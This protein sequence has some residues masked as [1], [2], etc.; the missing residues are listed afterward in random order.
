LAPAC[1]T[2]RQMAFYLGG[3]SAAPNLTG[4]HFIVDAIWK[5]GP[6]AV[7]V[8]PMNY[9]M[10]DGTNCRLYFDASYP[11]ASNVQVSRLADVQVVNAAGQTVS[12]RQWRLESQ[13]S[14]KAACLVRQ[15]PNGKYVDTGTRY[16]LPFAVV[17]TQVP[18][19]FA[20]YP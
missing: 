1:G 8:Q 19:P 16:Y 5:L 11:E 10:H 12:A 7:V 18:Y 4:P 6:G 17:I 20:T 2:A 9:G 15:S 14:H 13:G 3:P